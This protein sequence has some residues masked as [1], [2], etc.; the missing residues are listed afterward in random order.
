LSPEDKTNT[1]KGKSSYI[2][3]KEAQSDEDRIIALLE[4]QRADMESEI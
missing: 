1:E 3:F 4:V 2:A